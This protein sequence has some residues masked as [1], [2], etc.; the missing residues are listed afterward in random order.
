MIV[1]ALGE[2]DL[3]LGRNLSA[4]LVLMPASA[5][6]LLD[7]LPVSRSTAERG[8][9]AWLHPSPLVAAGGDPRDC[10]P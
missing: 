5:S 9:E 10:G 8:D 4:A 6:A 1:A 2:P 3:G 7:D